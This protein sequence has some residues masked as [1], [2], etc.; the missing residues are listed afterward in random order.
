MTVNHPGKRGGWWMSLNK[1]N[2]S[3]GKGRRAKKAILG[4]K[5]RRFRLKA[6][7]KKIPS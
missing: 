1:H 4:G 6:Q 7:E 2:K 3:H 5:K